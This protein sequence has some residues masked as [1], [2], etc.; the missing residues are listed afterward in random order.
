VTLVNRAWFRVGS[1][2]HALSARTYGITTLHKGHVV[3]RGEHLKFRFRS[4]NRALVRTT[5]VDAELAS[6]VRELLALPGG[7]RLF[8]FEREGEVVNLT[9]PLLNAYIA[10]HLG[11]GLTAK[12]FRTWGGTLTAA[13]ALA[14]REPP[15]SEAEAKRVLASVM[16]R[17]GTEL[18]NTAAVARSSYVSPAVVELYRDGITLAHFHPDGNPRLSARQRG[19]SPDERALLSLL[20]SW[21]ARNGRVRARAVRSRSR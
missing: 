10:E 3:V 12:D 21:R 11:E 9:A 8:R 2:R 13:I 17:V 7:A 6:A 5:L 4:K 16:R 19:L 15:G 14:G 18:G 1:E 20:R